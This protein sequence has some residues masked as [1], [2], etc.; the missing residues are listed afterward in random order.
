MGRIRRWILGLSMFAVLALLAGCG[1]NQE[2]EQA[3]ADAEQ[4]LEKL[5]GDLEEAEDQLAEAE[6]CQD[7]LTRLT[8]E[9]GDLEGVLGVGLSYDEY[10]DRVQ[11]ISVAYN[12]VDFEALSIDC[13]GETGL[14]A[15]K[16][17]NQY[18][19]AGGTW[20]DCITDFDCDVDSIDPELQKQ[21]K[22]ASP[23]VESA[24]QGLDSIVEDAQAEVDDIEEEISATEDE[25]AT[26]DE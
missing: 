23:R 11:D 8:R 18:A 15:E 3:R 13:V 21:W 7:E 6:T 2:A 22:K 25:L 4:E 16:A 24:Q 19:A 5:Q 1:T 20:G 26:S 12:R 17:F 9:L 14:D 10:S